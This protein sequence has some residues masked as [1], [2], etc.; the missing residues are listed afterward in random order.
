M[1]T[2]PD[3]SAVGQ[4]QWLALL[5]PWAH[6]GIQPVQYRKRPFNISNNTVFVKGKTQEREEMHNR[7]Q[8]V[9]AAY[10]G[11]VIVA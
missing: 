4:A 9:Q 5:N 7:P 1:Q 3:S 6:H 8:Q 2:I 10:A 11:V